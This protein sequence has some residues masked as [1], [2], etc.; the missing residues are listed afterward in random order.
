M[1][2]H[3]LLASVVCFSLMGCQ[4]EV[5]IETAESI[6]PKAPEQQGLPVL[7]ITEQ[8]IQAIEALIKEVKTLPETLVKEVAVFSDA[9][10]N[11]KHHQASYSVQFRDQYIMNG[12]SQLL[13]AQTCDYLVHDKNLTLMSID[14]A[15][16]VKSTYIEHQA[17][18]GQSGEYL[19]DYFYQVDTDQVSVNQKV[20]GKIIK[21]FNGVAI[22]QELPS[23]D[24][25]LFDKQALMLA[26][27]LNLKL[28]KLKPDVSDA[29]AFSFYSLPEDISA[30]EVYT[31]TKQLSVPEQLAKASVKYNETAL[32]GMKHYL[33]EIA[34]DGS[35]QWIEDGYS[36]EWY[37]NGGILLH[38]GFVMPTGVSMSYDLQSIESV[39]AAD[40]KE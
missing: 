26:E 34:E 15:A 21:R 19:S 38:H 40:C 7:S 11:S 20:E 6:N 32:L 5:E 4:D 1:F 2:R 9:L 12:E 10:N 8:D 29:E 24:A 28:S 13:I 36:I 25:K 37:A 18:D 14:Q 23:A 17:F 3:S 35:R 27:T 39:P 22:E 33:L 30:N 16:L 31:V